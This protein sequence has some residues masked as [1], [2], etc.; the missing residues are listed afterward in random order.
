MAITQALTTT[1]KSEILQGVHN[2][3]AAGGDVFKIALYTAAAGLSSETAV[4]TTSGEVVG[5]G[6]T[7]GGAILTNLGVATSGTAAYTS[8]NNVVWATATIAASGAL[9]YNSSKGNKTVAVLN[10]G[11]TYLATAAPFTITFPPN[12]AATAVVIIN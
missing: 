8:W 11:G 2:F 3:A 12:S 4:Y 9:I 5:T 6:Y 1:F 7:A 10:F